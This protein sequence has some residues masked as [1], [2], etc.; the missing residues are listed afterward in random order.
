MELPNRTLKRTLHRNEF[1]DLHLVL[2]CVKFSWHNQK[3][4]L[5]Q[6]LSQ[7]FFLHF[8]MTPKPILRFKFLAFYD[9]S[10]TRQTR[11]DCNECC[12][13]LMELRAGSTIRRA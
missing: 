9:K 6:C 12:I 7:H 3:I 5:D 13:V 10:N 2:S 4:F 8:R 11:S 1:S